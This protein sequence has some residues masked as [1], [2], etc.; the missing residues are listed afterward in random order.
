[1]EKVYLY[2]ILLLLVL[3]VKTVLQEYIADRFHS[4]LWHQKSGIAGTSD[5]I[6]LYYCSCSVLIHFLF[7]IKSATCA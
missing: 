6:E 1:M 7:L 2:E 3:F 5:L 4:F